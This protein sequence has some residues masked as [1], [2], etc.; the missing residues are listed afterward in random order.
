MASMFMFFYLTLSLLQGYHHPQSGHVQVQIYVGNG[1]LD[2]AITAMVI[3]LPTKRLDRDLV[4]L[5]STY[6]DP[7]SKLGTQFLGIMISP[8]VCRAR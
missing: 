8:Q 2:V 5:W 7:F 4:R 3:V 6:G 1:P